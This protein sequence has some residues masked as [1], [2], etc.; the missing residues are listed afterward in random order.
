MVDALVK[1]RRAIK[2]QGRNDLHIYQD[3]IGENELSTAQ[4]MNWTKLRF[5]GLV[6]KVKTED[7]ERKHGHWLLTSRGRR[8]LD[9]EI[10]IHRRVQT[11]NNKVIERDLEL[12]D[13]R[14]VLQH[15]PVFDDYAF[16]HATKEPVGIEVMQTEMAL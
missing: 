4:Q 8:F 10:S 1:F 16:W 13:V 7:G 5:H 11:L 6:A 3:L 12:V 15:Q 14:Q 9:G 2:E